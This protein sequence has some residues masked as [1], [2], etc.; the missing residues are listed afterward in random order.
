MTLTVSFGLLANGLINNLLFET[1]D[2]S[3]HSCLLSFKL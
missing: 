1:I 2:A 3:V